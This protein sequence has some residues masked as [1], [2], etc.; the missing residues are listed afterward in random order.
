MRLQRLLAAGV[1]AVVASVGVGVGSVV[2]DPVF[3][4]PSG[5]PGVVGVNYQP[6][7]TRMTDAARKAVLDNLAAAGT[8]WVRIDVSW[9]TFQPSSAG[10]FDAAG[11]ASVDKR[12]AEITAR[13]MK[14]LMMLY[15]APSWA[16]GTT[17]KS[18]RPSKASD[19]ANVCAW[20]AKHYDGSTAGVKIDAI[21]MWNEPNLDTFWNPSPAGTQVSDF[22]N[23]IKAAGPAI[24]A[25]NPNLTRIVGSPTYLGIDWYTKFYQTAGVVGS[26]DALGI[27][28]YQSPSNTAPEAYDSKY[29]NYYINGIPKLEALMVAN[30]DPAK[31]WATEFGWSSHDSASY[32]GVSAAPNWKRGVTETQ[33]AQ[34]FINAMTQLAKYPRVQAAF[35]YNAWNTAV[36]DQQED[37]FGITN[38]DHTR[39]PAWYALR[40]INT[41]N[42]GQTSPAAPA[43]LTAT[44]ASTSQINLQWNASAGATGYTVL[45]DGTQIGTGTAPSFTDTGLA[46]GTKYTY[47]VRATNAAGSSGDCAAVSATTKVAAPAAPTGLS[48]VVAGAG[49]VVLSWTSAAGADSYMVLR[50]GV[51][52]GLAAAASYTDAGLAAATKYTYTVKAVNAGG[53]SAASAAVSATTLPNA[54]VAPTGL[55]AAA[56]GTDQIK[57]TWA[58]TAG[59]D[60]YLVYRD[61]VQV[62]NPVTSGYTDAGL[63]AATKYTYTVKAVNTGGTSPASS[64]ASGTTLPNAPAAPSSLTATVGG[65]DNVA[66]NWAAAAGAESYVVLRDGVQ[67]AAPAVTSYTD[68]GLTAATKYSYVVKAVNA[69]GTS[70]ASSAASVTTLPNAPA[71]PAG[72]TA[73]AVG[74]DRVNLTWTPAAGAD[75]YL[76]FRNGAQVAT[77][78]TASYADIGLTGSTSYTYTV[79]AVNAGGGSPASSAATVTTAKLIREFIAKGSTWKYNS[80]GTDLGTAWRAVGYADSAWA[81]GAAQLGYGE[82]DEATK[83]PFGS[84]PNRKPLTN[85]LRTTFSAGSNVADVTGMQLEL[86]VDDGAVIYLNG[87]EIYRYNLPTGTITAATKASRYIA[88]D[89]ENKW[90]TFALPTTGLVAGTNTIAV[91][92]HNDAASSS[93]L[94]FDLRLLSK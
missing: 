83:L 61:G 69:G 46:A 42:C 82:G 77:S 12:V 11:I 27:H 91:E 21:E 26:Y 28:P 34:Y 36:G 47:T 66:L 90:L 71:A 6:M 15:W 10:A 38:L 3:V 93:D 67:V 86:L 78:T 18:G 50:D 5:R 23:L 22:A 75:S 79:K 70:P 58:D 37:N 68:N 1:A 59:A 16:S 41:G 14:V 8:E 31:L 76:V 80:A 20:V 13:G 4:A 30:N 39:K 55:A 54:P 44:A 73:I 48:A 88:G 74:S 60:A 43:G 84:D 57:L 94:S 29:P 65:T 52:V 89:E 9:A 62:G 63:A 2:A 45:R 85:Y 35:W 40:C 7:W 33:Q 24:K 53:S 19:Y 17:A 32:G 49:K 72:L 25:A 92:V 51:Q 81:S 87:T 64:A 56:V